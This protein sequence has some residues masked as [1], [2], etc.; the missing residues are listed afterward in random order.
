[1]PSSRLVHWLCAIWLLGISARC[2][3]F[4][5]EGG[6]VTF[7][8]YNLFVDWLPGVLLS[9]ASLSLLAAEFHRRRAGAP[10]GSA[11][12]GRGLLVALA[13]ASALAALACV[14]ALTPFADALQGALEGLF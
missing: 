1:M 9:I 6:A 2:L 14:V 13:C 11:W 10:Q 8:P 4:Q 12:R 3:Q 5:L 7:A